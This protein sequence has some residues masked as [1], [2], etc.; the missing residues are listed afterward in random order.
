MAF[1]DSN[2]LKKHVRIHT[3]EKPFHCSKCGKGHNQRTNRNK[4]EV[5][6]LT[7]DHIVSDG[8]PA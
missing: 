3:G 6:C 2:G 7:R 1:V 4:H 5:A 8:M